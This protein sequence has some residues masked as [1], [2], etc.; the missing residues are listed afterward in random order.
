MYWSLRRD[1]LCDPNLCP[2]ATEDGGRCD[3]C[4][5]NRLDEAE[6]SEPRRLLR[7]ALDLRAASRM[8]IQLTLDDVSADEFQAMLILDEEH[9]RWEREQH[10]R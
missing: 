3:A 7:R 8:G 6:N 1:Q 9:E 10:G 5:L 4:P 2:D